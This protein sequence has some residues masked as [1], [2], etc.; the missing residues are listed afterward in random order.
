MEI[1]SVEIGDDAVG[2]HVNK[3]YFSAGGP[4]SRYACVTSIRCIDD[5]ISLCLAT[6][7]A[8]ILI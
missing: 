7:S 4:G 1:N 3:R 2:L 5:H 6:S 8:S